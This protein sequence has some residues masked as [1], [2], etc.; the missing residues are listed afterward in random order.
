MH[1]SRRLSISDMTI[2]SR[3]SQAK[4]LLL[5]VSAALNGCS[6]VGAPSFELFGAFFPAWMFCGLFGIVCALSARMAFVGSGLSNYLP[7]QLLVCT[8]TGV[9]AATSAW[10]LWFGR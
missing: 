6:P 7:H 3:S 1:A 4:A 10:L 5:P 8:A 9:I 2:R